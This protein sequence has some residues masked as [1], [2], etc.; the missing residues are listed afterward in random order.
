[1]LRMLVRDYPGGTFRSHFAAKLDQKYYERMTAERMFRNRF[2]MTVVTAQ[3]VFVN[4]TLA[5]EPTNFTEVLVPVKGSCEVTVDGEAL[6]LELF[7]ALSVDGGG[8]RHLR[9]AD[10]SAVLLRIIDT[11]VRPEERRVGKECVRTC[12]SRGSPD[13]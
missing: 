5:I 3:F 12:R 10:Q 7:D 9:S 6:H 1:M 11:R 4:G 2:F 13:P 8:A